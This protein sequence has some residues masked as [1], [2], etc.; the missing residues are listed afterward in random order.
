MAVSVCPADR[1]QAPVE[2]VWSLLM[3]PDGYGQF[4][5]LTI[6]RVEPAGPAAP[7]QRF[8]GWSRALCRR[9]SIVG[10]VAEVDER[11][12]AIRFHTSLP[13]GIMGDNRISCT[14]IEAGTC[15]L[16]YG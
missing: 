10:E 2:V 8:V 14:P 7:G 9:W 11:R 15:M 1:V 6:E 5:D 12:H 3:N 16:R 13:F 4:F